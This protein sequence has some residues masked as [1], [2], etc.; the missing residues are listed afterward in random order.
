MPKPTMPC[1]LS[2]VLN[3]RAEPKRS[4]RST[5]QRNTP[6]NATSSPKIT[7]EGS[8]DSA[9]DIASFSA[10]NRFMRRV[11]PDGGDDDEDE[12]DSEA[13]ESDGELEEK[14]ASLQGLNR[15]EEA[16]KSA[17]CASSA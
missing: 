4:R 3:T 10:V 6:P 17:A 12:D 5:V 7:S 1:S 16:D 2:G 15:R 13:V 14:R 9:I 8:V 11:G